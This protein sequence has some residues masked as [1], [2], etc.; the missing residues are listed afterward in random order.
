MNAL[1]DKY[2][3]LSDRN[4]VSATRIVPFDDCHALSL[5]AQVI[6][7]QMETDKVVVFERGECGLLFLFNFHS[8]QS[9][10]DYRIGCSHMAKYKQLDSNDV[11]LFEDVRFQISCRSQLGCA[12]FRWP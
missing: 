1:E 12:R 7:R 11:Q 2:R 6:S 8:Q 10:A 9:F 5:R 3:W 4:T